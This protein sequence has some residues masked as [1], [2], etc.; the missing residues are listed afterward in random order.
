MKDSHYRI[1]LDIHSTQSQV[2]LP[3]KQGDTSRKVFISLC[4]G[5][6]PYVIEKDC[7]AV[8][9]AKKPDGTNIKNNCVIADNVIEYTITEQTTAKS[10]MVDCEINL[11]G[12]GGGLITSPHFTIIV[13]SRA[14]SDEDI[15]ESFSDYSAL[16]EILTEFPKFKDAVD[17]VVTEFVAT[18][19]A[20]LAEGKNVVANALKGTASGNPVIL[21][22]VS[23]VEHEM[24]VKLSD[25]SAT[26]TVCGKNLFDKNSAKNGFWIN[27]SGSVETVGT[28]YNLAEFIPVFPNT[29]YYIGNRG[30]SRTKFYTKEKTPI[31]DV[32]DT[33]SNAQTFTTPSNCYYVSVTCTVDYINELQLELG[34]T[35]SEYEPFKGETYTPSADGTVEGVTSLYPTTTLLCDTEGVTIDVEYNKDANKVIAELIDLIGSGGGGTGGA[36]A[37]I[38]D[39]T[40]LASNWVGT[41]SPYSQV[42]TVEGATKR[43]Q[44]DL[45]P[46]AEQLAI[47]HNKDLAFVTENNNGVITVYAIGQKPANDYTIQATVT[48]VK[49]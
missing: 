34:K 45:T 31:T 6:K 16:T 22:D 18:V 48:E 10:G 14:V 41:S 1:S 2:S 21:G 19:E 11:Y 5:G 32:F 20:D 17:E 8:F 26:V 24:K 3:V 25:P 38:T 39:V 28:A 12:V 7:F 27:S 4:E 13:D 46:S 9:S 40:I 29:A 30:S 42:V 35:A 37:F 33:G 47:F 49:V 23:P 44:V 15:A 43:S 36:S